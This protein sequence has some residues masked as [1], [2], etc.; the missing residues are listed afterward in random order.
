MTSPIGPLACLALRPT[1]REVL[2]E[3]IRQWARYSTYCDFAAS[4]LLSLRIAL[5]GGRRYGGILFHATVITD[6]RNAVVV[7]G[8]S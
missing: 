2:S 5:V 6:A 4:G 7:L 1:V 8:V 3:K